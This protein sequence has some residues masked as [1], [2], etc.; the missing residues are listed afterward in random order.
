MCDLGVLTARGQM[1]ASDVVRM[2]TGCVLG[3][4]W[5]SG[6]TGGPGAWGRSWGSCRLW[7]AMC[8]GGVAKGGMGCGDGAGRESCPVF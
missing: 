3:R 5:G 4:A 1:G 6:G 7:G 2:V 8:P